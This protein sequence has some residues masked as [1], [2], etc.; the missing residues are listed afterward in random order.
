MLSQ[1]FRVK[2]VGTSSTPKVTQRIAG[3]SFVAG[4]NGALFGDE[5]TIEELT[6]V[7]GADLAALGGLGA[8]QGDGGVVDTLEDE[9]VLH[10]GGKAHGDSVNHNDLLDVAATEEVLDL[11]ALAVNNLGVDGEMSVDTSH[12]VDEGLHII[13]N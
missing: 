3:C 13:I 7:L 1:L 6:L 5:D 2:L 12:L 10:F 4:L 8:H 11:D 9:F